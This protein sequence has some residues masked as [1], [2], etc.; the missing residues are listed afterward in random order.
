MR[1]HRVWGTPLQGSNAERLEGSQGQATWRS[2]GRNS[3]KRGPQMQRPWRRGKFCVSDEQ[4]W[5]RTRREKWQEMRSGCWCK[6]LQVTS[7]TVTFNLSVLRAIDKLWAEGFRSGCLE[8][9]GIQSKRLG[10]GKGRAADCR[11]IV[12][13]PFSLEEQNPDFLGSS[14]VPSW[15]LY[16]LAVPYNWHR[17]VTTFWP[18]NSKKTIGSILESRCL[19]RTCSSGTKFSFPLLLLPPVASLEQTCNGWSFCGHL[20]SRGDL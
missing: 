17:L 2:G 16:S 4:Q 7:R 15:N 13:C 14:N 19:K 10:G 9:N 8:R 11:L 20:N 3:R 6:T 1:V 18:K 5:G 12:I